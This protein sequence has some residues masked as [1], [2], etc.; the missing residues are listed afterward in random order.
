MFNRNC[1]PHGLRRLGR[2]QRFLLLL[3]GS[4]LGWIAAVV[5]TV[6]LNPRPTEP[7]GLASN[8]AFL[9]GSHGFFYHPVT[10]VLSSRR[11]PGWVVFAV[12]TAIGISS[13][14]TLVQVASSQIRGSQMVQLWAAWA[15]NASLRV[16]TLRV[17][18]TSLLDVLPE[19]CQRLFVVA[20]SLDMFS[21][22]TLDAWWK[23]LRTA[24]QSPEFMPETVKTAL[25]EKETLCTFSLLL[26]SSNMGNFTCR[27]IFLLGVLIGVLVMVIVLVVV[28]TTIAKVTSK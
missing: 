22:N 26:A 20:D 23:I 2:D 27:E 4:L 21:T 13:R 17:I 25:P 7:I 12:G 24:R 11:Y 14:L 15:L 16:P 19:D 8:L 1:I 9:I 6:D 5:I 28:V 3:A 18:D 10:N